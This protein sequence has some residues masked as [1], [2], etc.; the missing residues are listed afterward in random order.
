MKFPII[1]IDILTWKEIKPILE[2]FGY[3]IYNIGN[4][5]EYPYLCLNYLN[6]LG[7]CSNIDKAYNESYIVDNVEEFLEKAAELMGKKYIKESSE[8]KKF[9]C[10][11]ISKEDWRYMKPILEG[12]GYKTGRIGEV[13]R[14]SILVL[15]VDGNFGDCEILF[16]SAYTI[17]LNKYNRYLVKDKEIFLEKAKELMDEI[18]GKKKFTLKDIKPGMV[19][20]LRNQD[21]MLVIPIEGKLV[22]IDQECSF[23]IDSYDEELFDSER[24][25]ELDIVKVFETVSRPSL[26]SLFEDSYL[27]L[28]WE[29]PKKKEISKQAIRKAFNIK[30]DEEFEIVD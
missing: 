27:K 22:L 20:E 2:G 18:C 7:C 19:V 5:K 28:I 8:E 1:E 26:L 12:F 25:V 15:N 14:H 24:L 11:K 29:R 10:I 3:N 4:W 13:S 23:S 16:N 30:P 21:R 17:T 9:P 6:H